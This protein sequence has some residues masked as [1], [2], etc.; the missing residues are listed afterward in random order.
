MDRIRIRSERAA[1]EI[2][3]QPSKMTIQTA[4]PK[5]S[6]RNVRPVMRVNREAPTFKVNWMEVRSSQSGI[7]PP[8]R[9]SKE[10]A[11][12]GQQLLMEGVGRIAQEGD[13][14]SRV[15]LQ[16]TIPRI[17]RQRYMSKMP[18]LNIKSVPETPAK[19]EWSEG[20]MQIEWEDYTMELDWDMGSSP[21]IDVEPYVVEIKLRNHPSVKIWVERDDAG[22]LVSHM[23]ESEPA[24]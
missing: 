14:M 19:I 24:Q 9:Y 2:T 10:N 12:R 16:Q 15:D 8:I 13:K 5:F 17:I 4:R 21:V 18:E 3:T 23:E 1:L 20:H 6:V 7:S 11:S 22:Q